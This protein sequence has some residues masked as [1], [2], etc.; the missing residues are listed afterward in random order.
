MLKKFVPLLAIIPLCSITILADTSSVQAGP[1]SQRPTIATVKSMS[2]GDL[3]CYV[4]L[5]DQKGKKSTEYADFEICAQEKKLLNKKVR[6]TYAKGSINDCQ[7]S[8]PCGKS[9]IVTLITKMK[10]I[11]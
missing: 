4:D 3:A 7:S 2:N 5:V 11:R 6:I 1:Q 9:K 10:I 8:E